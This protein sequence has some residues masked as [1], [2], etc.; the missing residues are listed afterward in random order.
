MNRLVNRLSVLLLLLLYTLSLTAL[1][2]GS[3]GLS[4]SGSFMLWAGALCV[5]VWFSGCFR[6]GIF[7]GLPAAALTLYAA[8]RVYAADIAAE[9]SDVLDRIAGAYFEHFYASG[10]QY[11]YA[12]SVSSHTL[13]MIF[14]A[15]LLASYMISALTSKNGRVTLALVGSLPVFAGC[16][17]VNGKPGSA[18]IVC[19]LLFWFLT[20]VSGGGYNADGAGGRT[21]FITALPV[22]LA[23]CALLAAVD[24]ANYSFDEEDVSLSQRFDRLGSAINGW[25]TGRTAELVYLPGDSGGEAGTSTG[26][27][28]RYSASWRLSNRQLDLN[29]AYDFSSLDTLILRAR[30]ES[31]VYTYLRS[32][33]YGDYTGTGWAPV[34]VSGPVSSAAFAAEAVK[35]AP[36]IEKSELQL[37]LVTGAEYLFLPY[38]STLSDGSD[39]GV[40]SGSSD[41][42]TLE[43]Y[44][45]SGDIAG[46][47][48]PEALRAAELEYRDYAHNYYTS[49]PE[50]TRAAMLDYAAAQGLGADSPDIIGR[51]AEHIRACAV[52][53]LSTAPYPSSDY[54]MYFLTE[55][56]RG[57]CVHF[58]TAAAVMYR[59]LGIPA[60]VAEGFLFKAEARQFTDVRAE[61]AH[62]W[63]EVYLDGVGWVPVEV[64]GSSGAEAARPAA[65]PAETPAPADTET[66]AETAAPEQSAPPE[67]P[68]PTLPVGV[69]TPQEQRP[70][71]DAPAAFPWKALAAALACVLLLAALPLRYLLLR[72][73]YAREVS[74]PDGNRA[75]VA[76][77]RMAVRVS[78]F[79]AEI[80]G[81]I[82][83]CAERASFSAHET[84][85]NELDICRALLRDM[86]AGAYSS[87]G[88]CR[89]LVFKYLKGLI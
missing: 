66:A 82:T 71:S 72:R 74:Q 17:A 12:G 24:P 25:L 85:Q 29:R 88:A 26:A 80:P 87:L 47:S 69:I 19:L 76:I 55:A 44:S 33:S 43:Y 51:V 32:S 39:T 35:A 21:V 5:C 34:S 53:D 40:A 52:Y 64:T 22:A 46:L 10:S 36:G 13:V 7:I 20:A 1:V 49:L 42:Y 23:L 83:E 58:A 54:A 28:P 73:L 37:R 9:L 11:V 27:E 57:Y 78:A 14:I 41:S 3:F 60:R 62:A 45:P 6:H 2:T 63:V 61:N 75:A 77:W 67:S 81:V 70:E 30:C 59:A 4:V 16:I 79:G 68:E 84:G 8:Y 48:V 86:T 31:G 18:A 38:Y 50:Q 89:K 56:H 15:F 65:A